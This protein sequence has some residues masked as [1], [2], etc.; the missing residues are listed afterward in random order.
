MIVTS[1]YSSFICG[2]YMVIVN[3]SFGKKRLKLFSGFE[4]FTKKHRLNKQ[5]CR[6]TSVVITVM[7]RQRV[8]GMIRISSLKD[9]PVSISQ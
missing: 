9:H 3:F 6:T 8:R 7:L 2:I 1:F 4:F 5:V